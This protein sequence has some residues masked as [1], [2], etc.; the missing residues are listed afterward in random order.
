MNH[1]TKAGSIEDDGFHYLTGLEFDSSFPVYSSVLKIFNVV[2]L[3]LSLWCLIFFVKLYF[4]LQK[5]AKNTKNTVSSSVSISIILPASD[6]AEKLPTSKRT[7]NFIQQQL[8]MTIKL[9]WF[10]FGRTEENS[11]IISLHGKQNWRKGLINVIISK[12]TTIQET[13]G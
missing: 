13:Q 4:W 10:T 1:L 7:H 2:A 9:N 11:W 3:L 8:V 6:R 5:T 12:W